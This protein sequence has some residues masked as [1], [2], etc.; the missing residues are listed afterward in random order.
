MTRL[1]KLLIVMMTKPLSKSFKYA[2]YGAMIGFGLPGLATLLVAF[3]QQLDFS[4]RTILSIH[5][6]NPLLQIIDLSPIFFALI[7]SILGMIQQQLED[8]TQSLEKQVRERDHEVVNQYQF[9]QA[10]VDNSP[11]AVVQLDL[12]HNVISTNRVFEELFGY[13]EKEVVGRKIDDL[14]TTTDFLGEAQKITEQVTGGSIVRNVGQRKRKDG[15]LI[16]VEIIGI[17]VFVAGEL[18]GGIGL[19]HDITLQLQTERALQESEARFR[20]L[21]EDSPISLWEEDFSEVKAIIDEH[22]AGGVKDFRQF[23][24][25]HPDEFLR[26]IQAVRIVNVNSATLDLFE[27]KDTQELLGGLDKISLEENHDQL[28]EEFISLAGGE[29]H[30]KDEFTQKNFSGENMILEVT[31]SIAPGFEDTWEKA[32]LSVVDITEQKNA[33]QRLRFMSFHDGLTGLYN[34]AYFEEELNRLEPSRQFPVSI[35]VCDVDN[36]KK[37]NDTHGHAEGDKAIQA[38]ANLLTQVFR[39][40]DVVARIGGDEFAVILPNLGDKEVPVIQERIE[41]ILHNQASDGGEGS[42]SVSISYGIETVEKGESLVEGFKQADQKM[43]D[44]KS[45][46]SPR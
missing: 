33:E 7:M 30:F 31:L 34:R 43:Y 35:L 28:K 44:Q 2:S 42:R 5:R 15:S 40:E 10:L 19:Y 46:K 13:T 1:V 14:V 39:A 9:F 4:V 27:A 36:L 11:F 17:P 16:E 41:K 26:C 38:A 6:A 18:V 3:N 37:I 21:F 25:D 24:E 29:L 20:S 23:F 45:A 32:F 12:D 8:L 22:K